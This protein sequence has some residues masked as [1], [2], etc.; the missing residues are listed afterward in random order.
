MYCIEYLAPCTLS[1]LF[2]CLPTRLAL[3]DQPQPSAVQ[4]TN[5]HGS[6]PTIHTS[7][8]SSSEWSQSQ[9]SDK[10]SSSFQSQL[11]HWL[12]TCLEH[13]LPTYLLIWMLQRQ[14]TEMTQIS[15]YSFLGKEK[16]KVPHCPRVFTLPGCYLINHSRGMRAI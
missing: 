8:F 2:L 12:P 1:N 5:T 6:L 9:A 10:A 13:T 4:A 14:E 16:D 3:Y 15:L 7:P 11:A